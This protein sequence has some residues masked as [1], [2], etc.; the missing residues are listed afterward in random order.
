MS[1]WGWGCTG[2]TWQ[3]LPSFLHLLCVCVC[4]CVCVRSI[5]L[6]PYHF[7]LFFKFMYFLASPHGMW[8]LSSLTR[9]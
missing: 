1:D 8:D 6:G 7:I 4:V 2:K 3:L 9:D 5:G